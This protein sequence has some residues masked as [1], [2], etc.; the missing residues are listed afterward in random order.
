MNDT[1]LKDSNDETEMEDQLQKQLDYLQSVEDSREN[2]K[3]YL[4][5]DA[6]STSAP[7]KHHGA[8]KSR[9]GNA[10]ADPDDENGDNCSQNSS[11]TTNVSKKLSSKPDTELPDSW[12]DATTGLGPQPPPL[13]RLLM[14][15]KLRP[16]RT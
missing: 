14:D 8:S 13:A 6:A 3:V 5:D 2:V 1:L 4:G 16:N 15:R 11:Y 7:S 10:N 12:I 9:N